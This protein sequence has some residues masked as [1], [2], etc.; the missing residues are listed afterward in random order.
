M[1]VQQTLTGD[2]TDAERERPTTLVYCPGCDDRLLRSEFR[3]HEHADEYGH[4]IT[5]LVDADE[6]YDVDL[7]G[8]E[9]IENYEPERVG[10]WY[11]I[12]LSYSV[13]YRFRVPAWSEHE[14]EEIAK[15][16]VW[17]TSPNEQIHVH[18][19]TDELTELFEDDD[20]V[21]DDYDPYGSTRLHE[22]IDR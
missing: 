11:D 4:I 5:E 8:D 12:E 13:D 16:W 22:V 18:T 21:P 14:A 1:S 15:E 3:R 17:D 19:R 20:V 6:N 2:T 10:A 9:D 7:E